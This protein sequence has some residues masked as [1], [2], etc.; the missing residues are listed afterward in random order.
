MGAAP[1]PPAI[2]DGL[3][4]FAAAPMYHSPLADDR[5]YDMAYLGLKARLPELI[6]GYDL[7]IW[8]DGDTWVQNRAGLAD[9]ARAAA[10]ADVAAAPESDPSYWRQRLPDPKTVRF[11]TAI[12]GAA[13]AEHWAGYPMINAGVF[14]ARA[15]SPLWALWRSELDAS[16]ER[17]AGSAHPIYSDQIPLHRLIASGRVS[18]HPIRAINNWM[19]CFS[20]PMIDEAAGR[21]LSPSAPHEEINIIHLAGMS[22]D[23]TYL[24]TDGRPV[25]FLYSKLLDFRPRDVR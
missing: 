15:G 8:L 3:D 16:R 21:L 23:A 9:L 24:T 20:R 18:F 10:N 6:P 11:Y 13:E 1:T 4:A 25:S 22:K 7:Y 12:Y 14:A 5:G 17:Q 2:A 19:V